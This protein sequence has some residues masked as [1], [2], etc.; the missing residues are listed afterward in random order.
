MACRERRLRALTQRVF[1]CVVAAQHFLAVLRTAKVDTLTLRSQGTDSTRLSIE[2]LCSKSGA[3]CA[4]PR[5]RGPAP[6]LS[7]GRAG[8][9]KTYDVACLADP[10]IL[11]ASI[12]RLTLPVRLKVR[13]KALSKLLAN[14]HSNQNDV[15]LLSL[16]PAAPG[17]AAEASVKRLRLLSFQDPAK[18][19][20]PGT[21][22]TTQLAVSTS[23]DLI[24][25]YTHRGNAEGEATVN[26]KDLKVR[27][28]GEASQLRRGR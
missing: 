6:A 19:M 13:P 5:L 20:L 22:V 16:P 12:D 28:H 3:R 15:T 9:V 2:L 10:E 26:L 8:L 23:D 11:C 24:A 14:F 1:D 18:A 27:R 7:A 25:S 4:A 21:H 17:G